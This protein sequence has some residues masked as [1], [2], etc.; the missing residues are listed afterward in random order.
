[1][2]ISFNFADCI[3]VDTVD[4]TDMLIG[5]WCRERSLCQL[6]YINCASHPS[7]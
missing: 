4:A 5:A 1:M 2:K 6:I 3:V 7:H